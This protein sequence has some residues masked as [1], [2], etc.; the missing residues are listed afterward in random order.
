MAIYGP[1]DAMRH[2]HRDQLQELVVVRGFGDEFDRHFFVKTMREDLRV[3]KGSKSSPTQLFLESAK[4]QQRVADAG[5][6]HWAT[7]HLAGTGPKGPY[8]VLDYHPRSANDFVE[9]KIPLSARSLHKIISG[10]VEGLIDLQ[11]V[12]DRPHGNLKP[13]NVL[14]GPGEVERTE[15]V[16][17]DPAPLEQLA[18]EG[19]G[20]AYDLGQLI[21][22][23]VLQRKFSGAWPIE[24]S[25]GWTS[26]GSK[27]KGWRE[28][29]NRLLNPNPDKR[30]RLRQVRGDLV[31]L[32]PGRSTAPRIAIAAAIGTFVLAA[33]AAVYV[34][35][36]LDLRRTP[37]SANAVPS[38]SRSVPTTA[39]VVTQTPTTQMA[40]ATNPQGT[41]TG[42]ESSV[43][44][45]TNPSQ[46]DPPQTEL[47]PKKQE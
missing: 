27:A 16:L 3:P 20:D 10:V 34:Y 26:L 22:C 25:A 32:E 19:R 9:N 43:A 30:P 31:K 21:H 1:Q 33:G 15:V 37:G 46:P 2:E 40:T 8:I 7:V 47:K 24:P 42:T 12:S 29:C 41:A 5:S 18:T 13:S 23:L 6:R 28:L 14:I 44:T 45:T 35:D 36:P 11:R 17:A 39:P 4:T 38:P